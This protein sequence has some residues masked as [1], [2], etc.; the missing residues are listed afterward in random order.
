MLKITAVAVIG[1]SPFLFN[2]DANAQGGGPKAARGE[3]G[4]YNFLRLP[5][6]TCGKKGGPQAKDIS[7]VPHQTAAGERA[8]AS[9]RG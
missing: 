8:P 1:L 2:G 7:Y 6:N 9:S 4:A 5:Q 3:P